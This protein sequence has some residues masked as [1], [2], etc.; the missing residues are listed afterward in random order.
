MMFCFG[1]FFASLKMT[2]KPEKRK[3]RLAAA[4]LLS[5]VETPPLNTP[6]SH[7]KHVMSTEGRF[8]SEAEGRHLFETLT[9]LSAFYNE[10]SNKSVS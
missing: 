5:E 1:R 2:A 4:R 8:L 9:A 3:R 7:A 6:F 10:S